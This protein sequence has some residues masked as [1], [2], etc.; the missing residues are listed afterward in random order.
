MTRHQ[1]PPAPTTKQQ[2][3]PQ[4]EQQECAAPIRPP[5]RRSVSL[6]EEEGTTAITEAR[7]SKESMARGGSTG[8]EAVAELDCEGEQ[9]QQQHQAA[10]AGW[11]RLRSTCSMSRIGDGS[12]GGYGGYGDG[13]GRGGSGHGLHGHG[14]GEL[15]RAG[16][17]CIDLSP[18]ALSKAAHL[19]A[20]LPKG[21]PPLS[22]GTALTSADDPFL[23]GGV[24]SGPA[25][26]RSMEAMD[27]SGA[28]AVGAP[29]VTGIR[30]R[31]PPMRRASTSILATRPLLGSFLKHFEDRPRGPIRSATADVMPAHDEGPEAAEGHHQNSGSGSRPPRSRRDSATV[32]MHDEG[33]QEAGEGLHCSSG[34]G[35]RAIYA[36]PERDDV[37]EDFEIHHSSGGSNNL[38]R[39]ASATAAMPAHGNGREEFESHRSS[40]SSSRLHRRASATAAMPE[41]E[42]ERED[43]GSHRSSR[44]DMERLVFAL[45]KPRLESPR[46]QHQQWR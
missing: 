25:E 26:P 8:L 46:D 42:D 37:R 27:G 38:H 36:V 12:G 15:P 16:L 7:V 17:L 1:D 19:A 22:K 45:R 33:L 39:R 4:Q 21:M 24:A 32:A 28:V 13:G 6:T 2:Q 20:L 34:G 43:L 9:Q 35:R 10:A 44:G 5:M 3:L 29:G 30:P 40:D 11:R 23:H 18:A 31:G 14:S 41:H